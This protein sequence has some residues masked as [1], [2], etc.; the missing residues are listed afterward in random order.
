MA[1]ALPPVTL[2][3]GGARSGKSA[4]AE[5]LIEAH[6]RTLSA[7]AAPVYIA[8]GLAS[9]DEMRERIRLHRERRAPHWITVEETLDLPGALAEHSGAEHPVLVDCLTLWLSN[10]L[11]SDRDVEPQFTRLCAGL[12]A[13]AGRVVLVS[14]EVGLGIVPD[15]AMA[16]LF[17][18]R[19]GRLHQMV[20]EVADSVLFVAAG[21]PLVLKDRGAPTG[22]PRAGN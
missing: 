18:D 7:D 19:A 6:C 3:L 16:R 10:L 1:G 13:P 2:V 8:T 15:N 9:D 22:G 11:H 20:A 4:L 14:N 21:L 17:R 12:H 5:R